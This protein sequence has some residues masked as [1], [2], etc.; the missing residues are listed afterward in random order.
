MPI[1]EEYSKNRPG[2]ELRCWTDEARAELKPKKLH[3]VVRTLAMERAVAHSKQLVSMKPAEGFEWE[4]KEWAKR[5]GN[6]EPFANPKVE[7]GK[8]GEVPG[9]TLARFTL[10]MEPGIVVP[11]ILIT[12]K[13]AKGKTPVVVMVAQGGK[14]GFLK[15]RGEVIEAFLKAGTAVCLPDVRGT[16]ETRAGASA[17]RTGSRT[18]VSQTNLILGQTVIGS[19]LRDLRTVIRW[20]QKRDGID[21]KKVGVWGDS[22]AKTN[23]AD[24]KFALPLDA[25]H[26][27]SYAEPGGSELA[28]FAAMYEDG[29]AVMYSRGALGSPFESAY[30]YYPH[31]AIVPGMY[32]SG[33]RYTR[34]HAEKIES[35]VDCHNRPIGDK[36]MSLPDAAKWAIDN[37]KK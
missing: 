16:G 18:S 15:E 29:I 33:G 14:A 19:Q 22:F 3:E 26:S 31:D 36:P 8:T 32:A 6:V 25:E 2:S 23:P 12:P 35:F 27:L 34:N 10:E 20:L 4:R 30:V 17:E 5:L 24:A 13:D 7:V 21:A 37:L 28:G 9:G 1:P 11:L